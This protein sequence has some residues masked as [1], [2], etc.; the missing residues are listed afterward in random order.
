M[1]LNNIWMDL[2][3][4]TQWYGIDMGFWASMVVCVI[5]VIVMNVVFWRMKP[6]E[7]T[8]E[9]VVDKRGKKR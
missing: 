4:T 2:F 6:K 1:D 9:A 7:K 3:G 5:I 8:V